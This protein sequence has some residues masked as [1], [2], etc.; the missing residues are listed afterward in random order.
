MRLILEILLCMKT[1]IVNSIFLETVSPEGLLQ[2]IKG[3]K[4]IAV[5]YDELVPQHIKSSSSIKIQPL[6]HI[7]NLSFTHGVFPDAMKIAKVIPLFKYGNYIKV[8]NY[9]PVS[10]LPVLSKILERLMYTRLMKFVDFDILYDFQFGFRKYH[11]TFIALASAV[12]HIVN[13][14]Q[15]GKYSIGVYLDFSKAF[16][17]LNY[18]IL[19]LELNHYGIR[20]I[21]L[22]WII[23]YVV[24]GKQYVIYN[25]NS[26]DIQSITCG[27]PHG[28]ILGPLLFSLYVNDLPNVSSI[29]FTIMF[30]DDPSMFI[31]GDD[32]KAMETQLN[33]ELKEVSTWLQ[34]NKSSLNVEK[35]CFSVFKSIKKSDL[36][37]NIC[38]NDKCLSRVSQVKFLGT[39]IDDKL[40]CYPRNPLWTVLLFSV[41]LFDLL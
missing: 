18:D 40:T 11:S 1:V 3:L 34:V 36:E 23:I 22:D 29:L 20:G 6:L 2:V 14:L 30:A 13:A 9:K 19:F 4:H 33:S 21:A 15:F 25:D 32:L 10:I 17:A 27:V 28:S 24:N 37:V 16:D 26:S 7:C 8:D 38:I 31:N 39:I 41:S 5:G 35:S 12:N